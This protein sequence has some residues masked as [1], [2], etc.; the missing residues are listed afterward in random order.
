MNTSHLQQKERLCDPCIVM[1]R[2]LLQE[3]HQ[4]LIHIA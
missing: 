1:W 2:L 3:L 4:Q